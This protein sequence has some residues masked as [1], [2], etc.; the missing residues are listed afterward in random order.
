MAGRKYHFINEELVSRLEEIAKEFGAGTMQPEAL[1]AKLKEILPVHKTDQ[2]TWKARVEGFYEVSEELFEMVLEK[3]TAKFGEE[4]D[5]KRVVNEAKMRP[6]SYY[7]W[8]TGSREPASNL[9]SKE[10]FLNDP[11]TALVKLEDDIVALGKLY[12]SLG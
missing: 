10:D 2:T 9:L 5:R 8:I 1:L 7:H 6:F 12:R 3:G 4:W 11:T